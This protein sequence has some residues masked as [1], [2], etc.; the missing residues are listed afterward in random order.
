M[1][2]EQQIKEWDG[3]SVEIIRA[4]YKNYHNNP[5]FIDTIL[6]LINEV[7]YQKGA[8]WLLKRWL[9]SGNQLKVGHIKSVYST[10]HSLEDWESKLHVLQSISYMPIDKDEKA[11]VEAFLRAS[12]TDSNK[13]IRAWSYNGFHELS[14]QYPEYTEEVRRYFEMALRD[15]PASVKARIRNIMNKDF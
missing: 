3:K 1:S 4:V 11:S 13:F 2:I 7:S 12:M 6:T 8:T 15:E 9:E 10:L 5:E 14:R